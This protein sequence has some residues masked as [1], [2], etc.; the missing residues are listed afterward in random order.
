MIPH[1][2]FHYLFPRIF[3]PQTDTQEVTVTLIDAK[4][5]TSNSNRRKENEPFTILPRKDHGNLII[6][7]KG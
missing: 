6:S 1:N 4:F 7:I 5:T 3:S 2:I